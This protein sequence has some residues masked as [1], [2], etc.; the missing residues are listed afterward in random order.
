MPFFSIIIP[1]Y[2]RLPFLKESLASVWAQTW[3][4]YEVIVV[5]DGSTDGTWE[6][7]L[8]LGLRV[9]AFRQENGGAGAARNLGAR[10]AK[11][12]YLAF[13]DS[14]DLW[15]PR[16][17]EHFESSVSE[18]QA[19]SL[20][21][22]AVREFHTWEQLY[23]VDSEVA[24]SSRHFSDYFAA[25]S[26][27]FYFGSGMGIVLHEAFMHVG[28]FS[29]EIRVAEDLDLALRLGTKPGFT[30]IVSPITL[31]YRRHPEGITKNLGATTLGVSRLIANEQAGIYPGGR[32]RARARR[33]MIT[34]H[35]R[36]VVIECFRQKRVKEGLLLYKKTFVWHIQQNRLKFVG[37]GLLLA[38]AATVSHFSVK[39]LG[40]IKKRI[41]EMTA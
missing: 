12:R 7:L 31:A 22:G 28:G 11:G 4:D 5:D 34:R 41:R 29:E 23:D 27:G 14:D 13:L 21:V 17:L 1:T 15:Y 19:T 9:A 16:T 26:T 32:G 3:T 10:H 36:P 24:I 30:K 40:R 18:C 38:F 2:N 20:L 6:Y 37:G 39:V 33:E 35:I 25:S 8:D